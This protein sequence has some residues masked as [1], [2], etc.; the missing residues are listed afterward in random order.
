MAE[1]RGPALASSIYIRVL[2]GPL[3]IEP[4]HVRSYPRPDRI[5]ATVL[6]DVSGAEPLRS[7]DFHRFMGGVSGGALSH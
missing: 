7:V 3:S 5:S 4:L 2:R 1:K 6:P